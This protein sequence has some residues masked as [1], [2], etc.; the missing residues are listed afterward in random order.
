MPRSFLL[1]NRGT[2]NRK[3]FAVNGQGIIFYKFIALLAD[4]PRGV[5][6]K[7]IHISSRA[8]RA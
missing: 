2:T 1:D 6:A 7:R 8:V 5:S 4:T 3:A